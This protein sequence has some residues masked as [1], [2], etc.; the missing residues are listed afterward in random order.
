MTGD[1]VNFSC[2]SLGEVRWEFNGGKLG[3]NTNVSQPHQ[4]IYQ[5]T[6]NNITLNNKGKYSCYSEYEYAIYIG[7]A[8]LTVKSMCV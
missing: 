3:N 7:V 2:F 1:T 5:L 6:I 8:R 4:Y